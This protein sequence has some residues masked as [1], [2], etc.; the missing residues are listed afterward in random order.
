MTY[1]VSYALQQGI[2]DVLSGDAALAA[3]V[4]SNIFD[5]PPSGSIP[6]TYVVL[7]D[8]IA[9]DKSSKTSGGA[10][11]ELDIKIVSDAAGFS[12]AKQVA[13]AICDALIDVEIPLSRGNL[14]SLA[15][16]AARAFREDSPGIRQINLKFRA[17][18]EDS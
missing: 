8:E 12:T 4:G 3:I 6:S 5:A 18:V 1:A 9:R 10:V 17:F 15:F 14:V 13:A 7:G 11:H 2:Y 16:R